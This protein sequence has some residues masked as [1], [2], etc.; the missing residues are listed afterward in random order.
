MLRWLGTQK[1]V[2]H[3]M[4]RMAWQEVEVERERERVG[5]E[6]QDEGATGR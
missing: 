6:P 2:V 4:P 1:A 5:R 3:R